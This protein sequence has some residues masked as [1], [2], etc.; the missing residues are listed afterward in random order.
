MRG[1]GEFLW[2]NFNKFWASDIV[3]RIPDWFLHLISHP[4][5]AHGITVKYAVWICYKW[6]IKAIFHNLHPFVLDRKVKNGSCLEQGQ[7]FKA[8][9]SL[10]KTPSSLLMPQPSFLLTYWNLFRLSFP[11]LTEPRETAWLVLGFGRNW[12]SDAEFSHRTR[13]F[14]SASLS[15]SAVSCEARDVFWSWFGS[16]LWWDTIDC[17]SFSSTFPTNARLFF[18]CTVYTGFLI[19]GPATSEEV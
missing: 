5:R 1:G 4:T 6:S 18:L 10:L 11:I 16:I 3:F 15:S 2:S 7:G 19:C 9:T 13:I 8:Y 17:P 14:D 12:A